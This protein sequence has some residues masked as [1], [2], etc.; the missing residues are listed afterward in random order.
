VQRIY[1]A[2]FHKWAKESS[3]IAWLEVADWQAKVLSTLNHSISRASAYRYL[4][5][6]KEYFESKHPEAI[7]T[8]IDIVELIN[9]AGASKKQVPQVPTG[10]CRSCS[11]SSWISSALQMPVGG[12]KKLLPGGEFKM[13][14]RTVYGKALLQAT[15]SSCLTNLYS[16][17]RFVS[18]TFIPPG[19]L[20]IRQS[21]D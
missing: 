9:Q 3:H 12:L 18:P 19:C 16:L 6:E 17:S 8:R 4:E 11:K 1:R 20:I 13:R 5:M 21:H 7:T 2:L 14:L 10:S 15:R